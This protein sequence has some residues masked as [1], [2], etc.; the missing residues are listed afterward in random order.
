LTTLHRAAQALNVTVGDLIDDEGDVPVPTDSP[1]LQR[2]IWL[3]KV[4]GDEKLALAIDILEV[5]QKRAH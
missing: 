2:A 1:E 5:L 3:L 4:F